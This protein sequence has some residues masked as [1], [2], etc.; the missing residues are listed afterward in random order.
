[1]AGEGFDPDK[2]DIAVQHPAVATAAG[3]NVHHL[4]GYVRI[5]EGAI[6]DQSLRWIVGELSRRYEAAAARQCCSERTALR[7]SP[8]IRR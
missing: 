4:K 8:G 1:M 5:A 3:N 7:W 2:H 6:T